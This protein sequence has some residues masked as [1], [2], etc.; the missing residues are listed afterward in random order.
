M[1]A[2]DHDAFQRPLDLWCRSEVLQAKTDVDEACHII[3]RDLS[4][5]TFMRIKTEMNL[6]L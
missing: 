2:S 1:L 6:I 5:Q 3:E 4:K